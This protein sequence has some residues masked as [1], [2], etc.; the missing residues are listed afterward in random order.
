VSA[1]YPVI[2]TLGAA[3]FLKEKLD[4]RVGVALLLFVTGI[5]LLSTA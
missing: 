3:A 2:A 5:T 4:W 1:T